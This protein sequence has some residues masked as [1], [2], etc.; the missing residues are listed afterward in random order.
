MLLFTRI[1]CGIKKYRNQKRH[2]QLFF[3]FSC[4]MKLKSPSHAIYLTGKTRKSSR[5]CR[6]KWD[7]VLPSSCEPESLKTTRAIIRWFRCEI[8]SQ[9]K[10]RYRN[11]CRWNSRRRRC[12]TH[13]KSRVN[14]FWQGVKMW[15]CSPQFTGQLNLKIGSLFT[16]KFKDNMNGN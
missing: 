1:K 2:M 5:F 8:Y 14:L 4:G 13:W 3:P 7:S 6:K 16:N 10:S 11:L 15:L 9:S 12:P